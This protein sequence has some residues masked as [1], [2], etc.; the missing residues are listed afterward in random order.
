MILIFYYYNGSVVHHPKCWYIM[1]HSHHSLVSILFQFDHIDFL[2]IFD[3]FMTLRILHK[4][5]YDY[6][7]NQFLFF[8]WRIGLQSVHESSLRPS[9]QSFGKRNYKDLVV[10]RDE[11]LNKAR[12]F[13][14]ALP[15][16]LLPNFLTS[17]TVIPTSATVLTSAD[18]SHN[19]AVLYHSS[20]K[21]GFLLK[22]NSTLFFLALINGLFSFVFSLHQCPLIFLFLAF[23]SFV[24]LFL[25][26][27][28]I[29]LFIF[30]CLFLAFI[31]LFLFFFV[32]SFHR[33]FCL[34]V[35]F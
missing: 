4:F 9:I 7:T 34:F 14:C 22:W 31:D 28:N 17:T 15:R 21:S 30:V 35:S 11:C 10:L 12:P 32:S 23:I 16:S 26:L 33:C 2:Y 8:R 18:R 27:I 25:T 13:L 3:T 6:H 1:L 5:G 20:D 19:N 24:R 29:L